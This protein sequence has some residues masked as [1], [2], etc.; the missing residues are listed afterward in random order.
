MKLFYGVDD[1]SEIL[2][3]SRKTSYKRIHNLNEEL[4]SEGFWAERGK[5]PIE[6]FNEKYPHLTD[7][8]KQLN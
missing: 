6:K 1:V 2:Q 7:K 3:V 8:L 5:V 4:K